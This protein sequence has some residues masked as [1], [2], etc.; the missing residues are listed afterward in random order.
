MKAVKD[1]SVRYVQSVLD[2]TRSKAWKRV[3]KRHAL[4]QKQLRKHERKQARKHERSEAKQKQYLL[5]PF[6]V[7]DMQRT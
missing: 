5:R 3:V 6:P 1:H 7:K 4:L 2:M